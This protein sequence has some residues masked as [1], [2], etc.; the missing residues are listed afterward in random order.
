MLLRVSSKAPP[1]EFGVRWRFSM[2]LARLDLG[3]Q[4]TR[5]VDSGSAGQ[6]EAVQWL[7][8]RF[9]LRDGTGKG[10]HDARCSI[11]SSYSRQKKPFKEEISS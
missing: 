2:G 3:N 6:E 10:S 9:Y 1:M 4:L 8:M 11:I 5:E 7:A